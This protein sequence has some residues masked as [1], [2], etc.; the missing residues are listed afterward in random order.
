MDSHGSASPEIRHQPQLLSSYAIIQ[1]TQQASSGP[2]NFLALPP[3][4]RDNI[5]RKVFKVQG[6][7]HIYF[8]NVRNW[9]RE[10]ALLRTTRQVYNEAS[11][12]LY[13]LNDFW[14]F[15][16]PTPTL[17]EYSLLQCFFNTVGS[18]NA[19]LLSH[20]SIYFPVI[21]STES[22]QKHFLHSLKFLQENCINLKT[23]GLYVIA[24]RSKIYQSDIQLM[25]KRLSE[26]NA[27]LTA[28]TSLNKVTV[29]CC[30]C[31]VVLEGE[32][33]QGQRVF[34]TEEYQEE[35]TGFQRL[36]VQ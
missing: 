5:Y 12:V 18:K 34:S 30:D 10:P 14:F 3:E 17:S 16:I 29:K 22:Q 25:H 21:E 36:S 33:M 23:L 35:I 26:I 9:L 11:V 4:L 13:S 24:P 6:L 2:V 32:L 15:D 19:S 8:Y 7:F 20:I 31:S 1:T 27:Q 28:I